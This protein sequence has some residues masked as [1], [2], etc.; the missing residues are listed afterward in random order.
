LNISD[1]TKLS[2]NLETISVILPSFNERENIEEAIN[3]I[4]KTLGDQLSEI[5]I[6]DDDSPDGT[7]K[8]VKELNHEKVNLIH[9]TKERGLAS[10]LATGVDASKGDIVVWLDC[11][12]GIPPEEIINLIA[13]LETNDVS[14]GSRYIENGSDTRSQWI[15]FSSTILNKFAQLILSK[16][17]K[18]YTSG[19]I[20]VKRDVLNHVKINPEGFGEYFIEFCYRCLQKNYKVVEYG[21]LYGNRK[22]GVS[23]STDSLL[24]FLALGWKYIIKIISLKLEK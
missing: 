13:Q 2:P 4:S 20:A 21:Y 16:D 12:L 10:A 1:Y 6:V 5:I 22:G 3:R 23:K 14:I 24:V 9:R 11:D 19:F 15:T 8:I 18:D 7:W 17:V